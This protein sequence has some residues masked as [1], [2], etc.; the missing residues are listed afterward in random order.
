MPSWVQPPKPGTAGVAP[1]W[2]PCLLFSSLWGLWLLQ[3]PLSSKPVLQ[4]QVKQV[5]T[6]NERG[7]EGR[8]WVI[9]FPR[10]VWDLFS[11]KNLCAARRGQGRVAHADQTLPHQ[12]CSYP[13][14][15]SSGYS[16]LHPQSLS[17]L[18]Q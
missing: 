11:N 7:W 13:S 15:G 3:R 4:S 1:A 14:C 9:S 12:G 2:P 18:P 10:A 6:A 17:V 16:D 8:S 5:A